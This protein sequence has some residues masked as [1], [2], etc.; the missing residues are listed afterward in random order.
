M[1]A[2]SYFRLPRRVRWPAFPEGL[3]G[4]VVGRPQIGFQQGHEVNGTL[5]T[6]L[7]AWPKLCWGDEDPHW[8][9][10]ETALSDLSQL[11]IY[12]ESQTIELAKLREAAAQ[13]PPQRQLHR[14][15]GSD[16]V[17]FARLQ[18]E[19]DAA[20]R[21]LETID[22]DAGF[23]RTVSTLVRLHITRARHRLPKAA[24]PVP[25]GDEECAAD[26]L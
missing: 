5:K 26:H 21:G 23:F 13:V 20:L 11:G 24:D 15:V 18:R 25:S 7:R 16:P 3:A 12:I 10:V 14:L 2:L 8:V 22:I 6:V 17:F 1:P 4:I 19:C 9:I